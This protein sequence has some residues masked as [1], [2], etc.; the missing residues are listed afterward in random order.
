MRADFKGQGEA[1]PIEAIPSGEFVQVD[2][3]SL[4]LS[5]PDGVDFDKSLYVDL[6]FIN[7]EVLCVGAVGGRGGSFADLQPGTGAY[8]VSYG[9][10]G[11]GGGLH[12]IL[13]L[14]AD[15]PTLSPVVVGAAG[16]DGS[17]G[18]YDS[19]AGTYDHPDDGT[20]GGYSSFNGTDCQASGGTGGKG[21]DV[22]HLASSFGGTANQLYTPG[23]WGGEGGVGGS[24]TPGGGGAGGYF[25]TIVPG[26]VIDY[27]IGYHTDDHL[28]IDGPW[29]SAIGQGGGGGFGSTYVS[30]DWNPGYPTY[31]KAAQS[32]SKGSFSFG[33]T[34]YYGPGQAT[35]T[36]IGPFFGHEMT[37][38]GS[39]GGAKPRSRRAGSHTP[40]YSPAG[41]VLIRLTKV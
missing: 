2:Q 38:P 41:I 9:G 32:G 4:L 16:S 29:D 1:I 22:F 31:A 5:L 18:E 23:G 30:N 14:L 40:G 11:G 8:Y 20:D 34:A 7:Y 24:I 10:A 36:D 19:F 37:V 21:T 13:G 35:T 12:R 27:P 25:D 15:L 39:G 26:G 6:G 28:P 33:D 3:N 17:D